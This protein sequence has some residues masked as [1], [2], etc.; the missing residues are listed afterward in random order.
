[1]GF[2]NLRIYIKRALFRANIRDT[3][4]LVSKDYMDLIQI[5]GI[6]KNAI[7]EINRIIRIPRGLE[8]LEKP[9]IRICNPNS[10]EDAIAHWKRYRASLESCKSLGFDG[11]PVLIKRALLRANICDT[12]SLVNM[13]YEDLIKTRGI[14]K[15]TIDD[16]NRYI[17]IPRGLEPL[18]KKTAN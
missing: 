15:V 12:Q 8:P 11:L 7:D 5:H 2:D 9:I 16:I 14:G 6:G 4:T 13:T 17:R 1:M 3:Q 18:K 10:R